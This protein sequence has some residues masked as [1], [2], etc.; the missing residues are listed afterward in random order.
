MKYFLAL[1][2]LTLPML[3]PAQVEKVEDMQDLYPFTIVDREAP[4]DLFVSNNAAA[5]GSHL[6]Y[7]AQVQRGFNYVRRET[8]VID[9]AGNRQVEQDWGVLHS[10]GD[11]RWLIEQ[12]VNY[13]HQVYGLDPQSLERTLLFP[14]QARTLGPAQNGRGLVVTGSSP[15]QRLWST[16]GT[17]AGNEQ[18][19]DSAS[20]EVPASF[21]LSSSIQALAG[22]WVFLTADHKA[23]ITDGTRA[24]TRLL[25]E[26]EGAVELIGLTPEQAIFHFGNGLWGLR[27]EDGELYYL[28]DFASQ[29][30]AG[31]GNVMIKANVN[32]RVIFTLDVHNTGLALWGTD[33]TF[34]GTQLLAP[35]SISPST[36]IHNGLA[37]LDDKAY[38]FSSY[39]TDTG[40]WETDGTQAGTRRFAP[41]EAGLF[42][43]L[44]TLGWQDDRAFL[45]GY[46]LHQYAGLWMLGADGQLTDCTPWPGY[47]AGLRPSG[48]G[49]QLVRAG[50]EHVYY[51]AYGVGVG[52]ELHR[53]NRDGQTTLVADLNPGV[54]WSDIVP[55]GQLGPWFYF[56]LNQD[57]GGASLYRVRDDQPIPPPP[58]VPTLYEWQQGLTS[59]WR[60]APSFPIALGTGLA[61]GMDGGIYTSGAYNSQFGLASTNAPHLTQPDEENLPGLATASFDAYFIAKLGSEDGSPAWMKTLDN[62]PY[63]T[64]NIRTSLTAAPGNGVYFSASSSS[65]D[66]QV[67][68]LRIDSAGQERWRL[69]GSVGTKAAHLAT[70][71]EGN[72]F[73]AIQLEDTQAKLGGMAFDNPLKLAEAG[74]RWGMAK[75]RTDG[76]VA[77]AR[78]LKLTDKGNQHNALNAMAIGTDGA[79]YLAYA[80]VDAPG[81]S[82]NCDTEDG[83]TAHIQLTCL[84]PDGSR[85]WERSL[86][87]NGATVPTALAINRQGLLLLSGFGLDDLRLGAFSIAGNCTDWY[88]FVLTL[89]KDGRPIALNRVEGDEPIVYAMAPN[90]SGGYAAAG[91]LGH[92]PVHIP[93]P[94]LAGTVPYGNNRF[95]EFFIRLYSEQHELLDEKRWYQIYNHQGPVSVDQ[96]LIRLAYLR[97]NEFIFQHPYS[98]P[99][100]TFAH[101]PPMHSIGH[102]IMRLSM[103][104]PPPPPLVEDTELSLADI[105]A[106]PNPAIGTL[107]LYSP[108]VDFKA[109]ELYLFNSLG[110]QVSIPDI[111]AFGP[112]RY[113][114]VSGLLSGVYFLSIRQGKGWDTMRVVV[115]R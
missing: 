76:T 17:S 12:Q 108:H 59:I 107:T 54:A 60:G 41:R 58:P 45:A 81:S 6:I 63:N 62:S 10:L 66:S 94:G 87:R 70:D 36:H 28:F 96:N 5:V 115:Q 3:A 7:R 32:D 20:V 113:L 80:L 72:L 33:G 4:T 30:I 77:W 65:F 55:L 44:G 99:L 95:R 84:A 105:Q 97:D 53:T 48:R 42:S 78:Q 14:A 56:V 19:L 104:A 64:D 39:Y 93:Y 69:Y 112:Y 13:A 74:S 89:S 90:E 110:Q 26:F 46:G 49:N 37:I 111:A 68:L 38:Y 92:Y 98:G 24:G 43:T 57:G 16:D 51:Q 71:S 67:L 100:D 22:K 18:L 79:I 52:R 23:Y 35:I 2:L 8:W 31:R 82:T 50:Q 21:T 61:K 25:H 114:D 40:G 73:V 11:D 101:S 91:M 85:R 83:V 9:Q 86:D 103:E 75:I 1:W 106:F 88:G 34:E 47:G 15:Q 109:A 27:Y 102:A 29:N